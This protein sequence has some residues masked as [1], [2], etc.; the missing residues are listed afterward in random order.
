M[1]F[2]VKL[3]SGTFLTDDLTMAEAIQIEKD[4]RHT[5]ANINPF[6]SADDCKAIMVA[7]L[8]RPVDKGGL[9]SRDVATAKVDNMSVKQVLEAIDVVSDDLPESYKDGLPLGEPDGPSTAS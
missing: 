3:D 7:F 5:W 9:G 4:T 6:R 2:Q 1:P 8:S